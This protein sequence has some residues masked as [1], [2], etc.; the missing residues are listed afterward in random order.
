MYI[1]LICGLYPYVVPFLRKQCLNK[2]FRKRYAK[3]KKVQ[4]R[5]V[6]VCL[7]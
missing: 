3:A 1:N 4:S 6:S 2:A 7:L 5:E